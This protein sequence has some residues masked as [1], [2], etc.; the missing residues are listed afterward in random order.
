MWHSQCWR[1]GLAL[2][3]GPIRTRTWTREGTEINALWIPVG[4][5]VAIILLSL[6]VLQVMSQGVRVDQS[7]T[8]ARRFWE[9]PAHPEAALLDA[10][11]DLRPLELGPTVGRETP[12]T[13]HA[14]DGE[15]R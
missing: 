1:L 13:T 9:T 10:P 12:E 5:G 14:A 15:D 11:E 2:G 4:S 8:G 3:R 6:G 7:S